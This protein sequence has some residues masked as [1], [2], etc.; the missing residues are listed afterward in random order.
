MNHQDFVNELRRIAS[1]APLDPECKQVGYAAT[2]IETLT[3]LA[4]EYERIEPLWRAEQKEVVRLQ[5]ELT[6][7]TFSKDWY[8]RGLE[9]I[10][11]QDNGAAYI[12]KTALRM[13][14]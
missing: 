1:Q 7:V 13:G 12:A 2:L 8:Y 6:H 5:A 11:R 10:S 14:K 4:N 3:K 9:E